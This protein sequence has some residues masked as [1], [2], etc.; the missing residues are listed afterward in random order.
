[1]PPLDEEIK[2][3]RKKWSDEGYTPPSL[4]EANPEGKSLRWEQIQPKF[5]KI[6]EDFET[7]TGFKPTFTSGFRTQEE[8]D[9]LKVP[10]KAKVSR[11]SSGR[12]LDQGIAGL[13]KEQINKA[14][15]YYNRQPG[16]KASVHNNNHIHTEYLGDDEFDSNEQ[17]IDQ[18]KPVKS[19]DP[20]LALEINALRKSWGAEELPTPTQELIKSTASSVVSGGPKRDITSEINE[21]KQKWGAEDIANKTPPIAKKPVATAQNPLKAISS[22]FVQGSNDLRPFDGIVGTG[23]NIPQEEIDQLIADK[24]YYPRESMNQFIETPLIQA[25]TIKNL[26][27][28]LAEEPEGFK[29]IQ[30][31]LDQEI[32]NNP[33]GLHANINAVGRGTRDAISNLVSGFSTP[34]SIATG[35]GL[36]VPVLGPILAAV[37]APSMVKGSLEGIDNTIQSINEGD[38]EGSTRNALETL[39]N[40]GMTYG[41]GKLALSPFKKLVMTYKTNKLALSPFKKA[42][43]IQTTPAELPVEIANQ[44]KQEAQPATISQGTPKRPESIYL[45]SGLG[46][47]Q[48]LFEKDPIVKARLDKV[49]EIE[50]QAKASGKKMHEVLREQ[51]EN[52]DPDLYAE[53]MNRQ[54]EV[55]REAEKSSLVQRASDLKRELKVKLVDSVAPLEDALRTWEK[56]NPEQAPFGLSRT[57]RLTDRIDKSFRAVNM[58]GQFMKDNGLEGVIKSLENVKDL[59]VLDQYLIAKHAPEREVVGKTSGRD[60]EL[61]RQFLEAKAP[62]FEEHAKVVQNY[63]Q[64]LLDYSVDAGL[65]SKESAA[66]LKEQYP[67]YVPLNRVFNELEVVPSSFKPKGPASLSKQTVVQKSTGSLRE[68]E[69]PIASLME[70]TADAFMQGERNKTTQY[71][72]EQHQLEG[73][74]FG[75]RKLKPDEKPSEGM[76]KVELFRNGEKEIWETDPEIAAAAKSLNVQQFGLLA[77]ILRKP[78]LVFKA[79]TT[80]VN[81]VFALMNL[82]KDTGHALT[83]SKNSR[84]GALSTPFG[85]KQA[86]KGGEFSDMLAREGAMDSSFDPFRE[87]FLKNVKEIRSD[88]DLAS[89]IKFRANPLHILK[90]I[91]D[92]INVGERT[93]R[94]A[95][96]KAAYD[97]AIKAGLSPADAQIKAALAA[98]KTTTDFYRKGEWGAVLN[99]VSPYLNAGIQGSRTLVR[100]LHESPGKT[101]AKIVALAAVP[102]ALATLYN[103]N[104]PERKKIYA[105]LNEKE[106]D[107]NIVI[108]TPWASFNEKTKQ[109]DGVI[110]IPKP[111]GI[112]NL[113]RP[114]TKYIEHLHDVD[115]QTVGSMAKEFL[116]AGTGAVLPFEPSVQGLSNFLIPPPLKGVAENLYNKDFYFNKPIV[117]DYIDRQPSKD[118]PPERQ[119]LPNTSFVANKVGQTLG[120]SPLKVDHLIKSTFG[121]MG[122]TTTRAVDAALNLTGIASDDEVKRLEGKPWMNLLTLGTGPEFVRR[123][124]QARG[125]ELDKK[126]ATEAQEV[127]QQGAARKQDVYR[128]AKAFLDEGESLPREVANA[129]FD[130]IKKEKPDVAKKILQLSKEK[131][132]NLSSADKAIMALGAEDG[133][134][135]RFLYNHFNKLDSE[136]GKAVWEELKQK[137]ILTDKVIQQIKELKASRGLR[138]SAD[139]N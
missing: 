47:L 126:V 19:V 69:S 96:A 111:Q 119:T 79:G 92:V 29:S 62:Q 59:D 138:E 99:S 84:G 80:G 56:N 73:N 120:V 117:P 87:Q 129:R 17:P 68:I 11:H 101:T 33:N 34:K 20:K 70:K 128:E 28:K 100:R 78:S 74:P 118:L 95:Q 94:I 107:D 121:G 4:P 135:A 66:R 60:L 48:R 49:A 108:I 109:W 5:K 105:D 18:P 53:V 93:T 63:A 15:N 136:E 16:V 14:L 39:A 106:K 91:E 40:L 133:T 23:F 41:A 137:G 50:Q 86:L 114:M 26:L 7:V 61:D 37:I 104:D 90:N 72:V 35:A 97:A 81:P 83:L 1:M 9:A 115:P 55:A 77:R 67:N 102:S 116:S 25:E 103:L 2:A 132:A 130:Q 134:R 32:A 85:L 125:G 122:Y 113:I 22:S 3:L 88:R 12:A 46:G 27:N 127:V 10:G 45:G 98:R 76:G 21:L 89:K 58:A 110:K 71:L 24:K 123:L 124:S 131:K 57:E 42:A 82:I 44:L 8:Q 36:A 52:F 13:S 75:L 64:K 139:E 65:I 38:V 51:G 43:P 6:A 31:E 54:R 30:E 112:S